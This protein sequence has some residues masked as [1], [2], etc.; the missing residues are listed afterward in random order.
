MP[1]IKPF[2]LLILLCLLI[3]SCSDEH[4]EV[5]STS[6]TERSL[7]Q[8]LSAYEPEWLIPNI[9]A[10]NNQRNPAL[11]KLGMALFFSK[12]LS[13]NFDVACASCHHPLLAGGDKLS[14][15]VGE[16][17]YNPDL[18]GPGRWHDWQASKDHKADGAPNVARHSPTTFNS[19]LYQQALFAD[20]RVFV[21]S[22][23]H[24]NQAEPNFRSPDSRFA[25]FDANAGTSLLA[26]Q[27]RFPV[28]S[29]E[30][31]RGFEFAQGKANDE[32]RQN[33]VERLNGQSA[34]LSH[35]QWLQ[36]FRLA[37]NQAN[38]TQTELI[39]FNNIQNALAAYQR[40]Q[41]LIDNNWYQ[42]L[43]GDKDALSEAQKKGALVFFR[44]AEDGGANCIACH[45]PPAFTDE[46]YHNIAMIQ[47][48]RGKRANQEDFGR[49]G[50]TQREVDRYG[51]RTPSLLNVEHTAPYGHTGAYLNLEDIIQ[52]HINP[53]AAIQKFD[54]S[55]SKNPQL[56]YVASLYSN[57][58]QLTDKAL[59]HLSNAQDVKTSLLSEG[60]QLSDDELS[61]LTF[62]LAALTDPC[63][64]SAECLQQ[65]IPDD[66]EP[67]PDN[68]R[69]V[70]E[71][72]EASSSTAPPEAV[73]FMG[74]LT[75]QFRNTAPKQ[76]KLIPRIE[77]NCN[78][79]SKTLEHSLT[80]DSTS[81]RFQFANLTD[82]SGI[83]ASHSIEAEIYNLKNMQR[84]NF[85]G[86]AAAGDING[87]CFNDIY[88]VTGSETI[89]A[90]Y[91]NNADGTFTDQAE[92]WNIQQRELSNGASFVDIDG[93]G[94]LDLLTSNITHPTLDPITPSTKNNALISTTSYKNNQQQ[95]F[96]LWPEMSIT[97]TVASWSFAFADY[98]SDGDLDI[99]SSH[100]QL[101]PP[102]T[103]HLWRN[104][105]GLSLS[106]V[107]KTAKLS[108]IHGNQDITWT[109]IFSDANNDGY[110]DILMTADF[111]DSQIFINQ[112]DA[113][114]KKK[115]QDSQL[116]D[117]NGMGAA[118]IDV[119][120]DGDLDWFVS[121]VWDPRTTPPESRN[122][123][124]TG[125]RLYQNNNGVFDDISGKAGVRQGYWGWG[126]CFADFNNDAWPDIFH[127][128][129]FGIPDDV[130]NHMLQNANETLQPATDLPVLNNLPVL[131]ER[132]LANLAPFND[133]ISRLYISNQ[134]GTFTEQASNWGITDTEQGRAV[135][136]FDYDRDGDVDIFVSNNQSAP[137]LYNNNARSLA[138]THFINIRLKGLNKN[139]QAV[140]AKVFVTANGVTQLQ[141]VQAGG[142]FISGSPAELH[143]GLADATTIEHIEIVWPQPNY[144]KHRLEN[145]AA[146]Q[147]ITIV[148]PNE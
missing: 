104:E 95:S 46:K 55:F 119:D 103:N 56:R 80:A 21:D 107:N 49:R 53:T 134:D 127:A 34:E 68:M 146:N 79:D 145:I 135:I 2:F 97:A 133:T 38:A 63:L 123:G 131:T 74:A 92:N 100:W 116:T 30:E 44:S 62:F 113:S 47:F 98:D 28:T 26:T 69:L 117:E 91:I 96:S 15:P 31:M 23:G 48:G 36:Q 72:T 25:Q 99:L 24:N 86:G 59:K 141:E 57:S 122:W 27:T 115:T 51:F 111:E 6:K 129:G 139:S 12:S 39:N 41:L 70:A 89:D 64:E 58:R 112:A 93:D 67:S 4:S 5:T 37:F 88:Y 78:T 52:H 32:V 76:G 128:N 60:F 101:S 73:K 81:E 7:Q 50:V 19:A 124:L 137:I 136:C 138:S 1:I 14:L 22:Q 85:S 71:F 120:N 142:S 105:A 110:P 75:H 17:A 121:S 42:Y 143:F 43:K 54:F 102:T 114:F 125:N 109:G 29:N 140:G 11:E 82:A 90:L 144:I 3:T 13:G 126:S 20:G 66:D 61:N 40:S 83:H 8:A 87:D 118:V 108:Y 65:W 84:L 106:A 94:D 130:K 132:L 147:F 33:I 45:Q 148:Q 16:A 9:E 77:N 10:L 18:L 35:N